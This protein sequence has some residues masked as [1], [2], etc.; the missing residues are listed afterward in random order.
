MADIA[1]PSPAQVWLR[2]DA[3]Q[4]C[5]EHA[6]NRLPLLQMASLQAL[7]AT[8]PPGSGAIEQAID[9]IED[10]LESHLKQLPAS[11]RELASDDPQLLQLLGQLH[12][13][14]AGSVTTAQVEQAFNLLA[15]IANGAPAAHSLL[16]LDAG[17][18]SRLLVLREVLHHGGFAAVR[19]GDD[20]AADHR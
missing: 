16:P 5:L 19:T 12:P 3:G 13:Q 11:P 4:A 15:D 1:P 6:G 20:P 9:M 14:Q 10:A 18:V 2:F 7:F 8:T 17:N